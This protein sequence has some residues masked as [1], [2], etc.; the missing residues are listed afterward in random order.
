MTT[1]LPTLCPDLQKIALCGLPKN[2]MITTA[3]PGM[4]LVTNRNNLRRFRVDSLLTEEASEVLYELPELRSLEVV[5]ERETRLPSASLPNLTDLTIRCDNEDGWPRL[6]HGAMLGKFEHVDF[7]RAFERAALSSSVQDTLSKFYLCTSHSWIPNYS[8]LLPF[9]QMVYLHV[10]FTCNDGCSSRV[11][12]NIIINLSRAMP[13]L[14]SLGLGGAPCRQNTLQK[15]A[16][17]AEGDQTLDLES[18]HH[19]HSSLS[20]SPAP[21]F[22]PIGDIGKRL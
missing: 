12:D 5:I 13:K 4:L 20:S 22:H 16:N 2:S 21:L 14:K 1:T 8:F 7:L 18:P 17:P 6:F 9:T 19:V 10:C 3:V 15:T 11:D